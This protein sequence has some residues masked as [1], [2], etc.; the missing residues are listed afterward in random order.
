MESIDSPT[1]NLVPAKRIDP[2][3]ALGELDLA[4]AAYLPSGSGQPPTL[5]A[6]R[7]RELTASDLDKLG[8]STLLADKSTGFNARVYMDS[9]EDRFVVAFAGTDMM[10]AGDTIHGNFPQAIGDRAK[11]YE[12]AKALASAVALVEGMR[13]PHFVGHSLGGGLAGAAAVH[14]RG[15]ATTF[16]AA[17]HNAGTVNVQGS[18]PDVVARVGRTI[19]AYQVPGDWLSILQESTRIPDPAG[20]RAFLPIGETDGAIARHRIPAV[21]FGLRTLAGLP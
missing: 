8:V 14:V 16:D 4:E 15:T 6:E 19:T 11:Q 13:K 1:S 5:V 7:Y 21:R 10:E 2:I 3:E 9:E 17:G 12:Q 18:H 20:T